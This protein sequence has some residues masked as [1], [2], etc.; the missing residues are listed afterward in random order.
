MPNIYT[1]PSAGVP[2]ELTR[3][4]EAK[5]SEM[6]PHGIMDLLCMGAINKTDMMV[7]VPAPRQVSKTSR[8]NTETESQT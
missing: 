1:D 7:A 8:P 5:E 4:K 2:R 6:T 3:C